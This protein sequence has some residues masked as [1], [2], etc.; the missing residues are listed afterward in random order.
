MLMHKWI[1]RSLFCFE[2]R[3][4]ESFLLLSME[5]HKKLSIPVFVYTKQTLK[6]QQGKHTILN[7]SRS[8]RSCYTISICIIKEIAQGTFRFNKDHFGS[9]QTPLYIFICS[10]KNPSLEE[11]RSWILSCENNIQLTSKD[12]NHEKTTKSSYAVLNEEFYFPSIFIG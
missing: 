10:A 4:W 5:S 3:K 9:V 7:G 8:R 12:R 2:K 1:P 11:V 6:W